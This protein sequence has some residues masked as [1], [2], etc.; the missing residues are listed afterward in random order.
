MSGAADFLRIGAHIRVLPVVHGSGDF[1]VRVREELLAGPCDCIAVP[2]PPSF[3]DAVEDAVQQLPR[4][5][6]VVQQDEGGDGC[7]FVPIDPCQSVIAAIRLALGEHLPR[8][9]IDLETPHFE[10]Q[11]AV[12]P[13]PYALKKVKLEA[14]AAA[15]LPFLTPPES[16]QHRQRIAWM[17]RRLRELEGRWK[18]IVFVCSALDWPWIRQAYRQETPVAEPEPFYAPQQT[19]AVETKTLAFFLGELPFVTALYERGRAELSADDNLSI[20]GVKELVLTA[21]D[22]LREKLPRLAQRVTPQLLSILFRYIRNLCL[23]SRRLTPDLYTLILAAQQ[24]GGDD[25]A[26]AVAETARAYPYV[27]EDAEGEPM[28]VGLDRADVPAWGVLP[29]VSRLPG[30]AVRWVPLSLKPSPTDLDRQR[31]Q[32]AYPWNPNFEWTWP[33]EDDR[34]D[35][36]NKHVQNTARAIIGVDLARSEKFTSSVMD[37]LD[38]RETLRNWHTGD[39]YVKVLPARRGNIE[40]AVFLF[41][42]PADPKKYVFRGTWPHEHDQ[43]SMLSFFASAPQQQI[44]GPGIGLSEYG[45]ML[46]LFPPRYFPDIWRDPQFDFTDT[47]EERLLAGGLYYSKERHVALVS[48]RPPTAAWRR[49][50][51]HYKKKLLHVPLGRF[52]VATVERLRRFHVLSGH[53]VRSYAADFIRDL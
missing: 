40:M 53:A 36:F 23:L 3:Q 6:A 41:D 45:G 4:I 18:H 38:M 42:V 15:L 29:A 8:A 5:H 27:A 2:L 13:D 26:L 47:L 43:Q 17:A 14:F 20:D 1:A 11:Q 50:A 24:T 49:L 52:N 46:L 9:F 30:P 44:V 10:A 31:W 22:R 33:P 12:F 48:D 28:R 25:F 37:G 39:L 32:K 51:K 16:E 34:R 35:L 21:R 19:C 7:S